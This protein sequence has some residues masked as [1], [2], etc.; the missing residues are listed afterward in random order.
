MNSRS[1][2]L[3]G[4]TTASEHSQNQSTE[5]RAEVANASD[6]SLLTGDSYENGFD[7]TAASGTERMHR[8]SAALRWRASNAGRAPGHADDRGAGQPAITEC[9]GQAKPAYVSA[10]ASEQAMANSSD[11]ESF[12]NSRTA[13]PLGRRGHR[14]KSAGFH[15]RLS[16]WRSATRVPLRQLRRSLDSPRRRSRAIAPWS[17]QRGRR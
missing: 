3:I 5:P 10:V 17:R 11:A 15:T 6:R 8:G 9:L 14:A 13:P 7:P 16:D 2:D 12:A 4:R 1:S